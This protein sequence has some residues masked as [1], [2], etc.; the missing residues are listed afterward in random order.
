[1]SVQEQE[2]AIQIR[3]ARRRRRRSLDLLLRFYSVFGVLIAIFAGGYFGL[4]LLAF[5]LSGRQQMALLS[6]GVGI[7]LA[8]L[9]RTLIVLIKER[10][11]EEIER[12]Y[13]H[14]RVSQ[15]LHTWN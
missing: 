11:A 10:D 3:S 15:F 6:A 14:E 9:S 5:E 12:L 8:L 7:T 1:M 4:S 13:E 2:E